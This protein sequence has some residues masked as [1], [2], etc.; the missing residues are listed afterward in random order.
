MCSDIFFPERNI[1]N[2]S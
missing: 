2:C 1:G